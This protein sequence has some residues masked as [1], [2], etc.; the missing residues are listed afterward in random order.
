MSRCEPAGKIEQVVA[1]NAQRTERKLAEALTVE[2]GIRPFDLSS[3]FIAYTIGRVAGG[4]GELID[5]RE[6][7]GRP[8][9][10]FSSTC[11]ILSRSAA[12]LRSAFLRSG[13]REGLERKS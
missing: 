7:H 4:Q 9:P 3:V 10:H 6:F 8:Q 1:V 13:G 5:N 2:E 12:A 11:W